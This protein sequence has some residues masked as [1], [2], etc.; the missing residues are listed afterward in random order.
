M[1]TNGIDLD[2]ERIV[3]AV[4]G[5]SLVIEPGMLRCNRRERVCRFE[6]P[7]H[8]LVQRLTLRRVGDRIVR[9]RLTGG[10]QWPRDAAVHLRVGNDSGGLDVG[11]GER[12]ARMTLSATGQTLPARPF[13]FLVTSPLTAVPIA[14][15]VD[16]AARTITALVEHFTIYQFGGGCTASSSSRRSRRSSAVRERASTQASSPSGRRNPSTLSSRA[17]APPTS[18]TRPTSLSGG[19]RS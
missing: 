14:A 8:P 13:A 7:A 17:D 6:D 18:Q 16:P 9:F 5:L 12:L 2:G 19:G 15:S 10:P 4:G 3:I 11:T 1:A